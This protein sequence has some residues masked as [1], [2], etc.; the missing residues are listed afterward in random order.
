MSQPSSINISYKVSKGRSPVRPAFNLEI[1]DKEV[2]YNGIANMEVAG[3]KSF[4]MTEAQF[5][6]INKAFSES[7]FQSFEES[8]IGRMRDLPIFTLVYNDHSVRYQKREASEKLLSLAQL[9]ENLI[10]TNSN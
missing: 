3:I 2:L 5:D 9:V 6:E 7:K 1:K 8:Y 10:P 4:E